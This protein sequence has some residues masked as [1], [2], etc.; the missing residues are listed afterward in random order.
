MK[1]NFHNLPQ[2]RYQSR[3]RSSDKRTGLETPLAS[4][5]EPTAS[6][7][8][9]PNPKPIHKRGKLIHKTLANCLLEVW[10]QSAQ[11]LQ[12]EAADLGLTSTESGGAG[13]LTAAASG[14]PAQC[15]GRA[16]S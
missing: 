5:E 14:T 15:T 4:P 16:G 2:I 8:K 7:S 10:S 1:P 12:R 11:V 6:N 3:F 9:T 13:S